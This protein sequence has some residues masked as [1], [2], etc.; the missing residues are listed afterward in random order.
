[1]GR[2]RLMGEPAPLVQGVLRP[3]GTGTA[4][5]SV[6]D[7]GTLIYLPGPTTASSSRQSAL[8]LVD[9]KGHEEALKAPPAVY[10]FPR[11]S[12]DGK[13]VAV[14][15]DDGNRSKYLGLQPHRH[16]L[17][18]PA[19]VWGQESLS[20]L[21]C[22]QRTDCV[23]VGSGGRP[24][25]FW[26]RADGTDTAERLTR[27]DAGTSHIPESWS[28]TGTGERFSFSAIKGDTASL[29]TFSLDEKKS[30]PFGDVRSTTALNSV[31]SPDGK[32]LAYTLREPPRVTSL[33]QPFP[34]TGTPYQIKADL[35]H[36]PMW[37]PDG[38]ELFY[39]GGSPGLVAVSV[40]LQP[41]PAFGIP[42]TLA[43]T[44]GFFAPYGATRNHDIAPDGNTFVTV[45]DATGTE[46]GVPA[47]PQIRVV[48]NWMEELKQ[49]VPTR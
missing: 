21:V 3:T 47:A 5:F 13:Q 32:W 48:L 38:K 25:I 16:N 44:V 15:T 18:S 33:I 43:G 6:S 9:R 26:Q 7:T 35:A 27:P 10:Q 4:E 36:H 28:R 45:G 23:P 31:F 17:D 41:S 22:R 8:V 12:P 11:F 30:A 2:L 14:G 29:F 42:M 40:T 19:H 49:R 24:G 34:P 46:S 37:S 39:L 20:H 1:M